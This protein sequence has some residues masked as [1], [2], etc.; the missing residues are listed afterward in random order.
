MHAR[1]LALALLAACS[2]P[3]MLVASAHVPPTEPDG[4][5]WDS[6]GSPPD[7]Y[8][9]V[10]WDSGDV[11]DEQDVRRTSYD[12]Q[13]TDVPSHEVSAGDVFTIELRDYDEGFLSDGYDF[14]MACDPVEID[15]PMIDAGTF[16]CGDYGTVTVAFE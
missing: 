7:V 10:T 14:I 8:A 13:F 11:D 5:V 12:P 16:T 9:V 6:D 2:P 15:D 3:K 4:T 1:W